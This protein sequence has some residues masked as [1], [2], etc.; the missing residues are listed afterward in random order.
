M[1]TATA[2]PSGPTAMLAPVLAALDD[3]GTVGRVFEM[4][5]GE[6]P[7]TQAVSGL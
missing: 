2:G 6:T 4:V 3:D 7:V 5:S 1:H